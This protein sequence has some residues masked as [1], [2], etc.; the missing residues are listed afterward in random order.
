MSAIADA[1]A[2]HLIA[3]P[4]G[5][6]VDDGV[7]DALS[8]AFEPLTPLI[9][10]ASL[11][12]VIGVIIAAHGGGPAVAKLTGILG[13]VLQRTPASDGEKLRR[14][15]AALLGSPTETARPGGPAP[16][17]SLPMSASTLA[18]LRKR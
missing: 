18:A 16:A 5:V 17:G 8:A 2:A 10:A 14:S 3:G 7:H 11:L 4:G 1:V 6:D 9:A 15:A 12:D 13:L